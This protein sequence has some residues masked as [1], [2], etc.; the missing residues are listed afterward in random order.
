MLLDKRTVADIT[1]RELELLG[2]HR[3]AAEFRLKAMGEADKKRWDA[4]IK[5][6]NF[7]IGDMVMLTHEGKFGLEPRY[8]GPYIVTKVFPDFGTYQLET[9]AGEPL[10][11]LVHVDR[12]KAAK[13]ERPT[14]PWYDPTS[15]RRAV[16]EADRLRLVSNTANPPSSS[17]SSSTSVFL[18]NRDLNQPQDDFIDVPVSDNNSATNQQSTTQPATTITNTTIESHNDS[19]HH[20]TVL[21]QQIPDEDLSLHGS[22]VMDVTE[23]NERGLGQILDGYDLLSSTDSDIDII[24]QQSAP[25]TPVRS[26]Q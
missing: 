6:T 10:E 11:S 26:N 5:P 15:S 17:A 25:S 21:Q 8:K 1:S 20:H 3:A 13:G 18:S 22:S 12:L 24:D 2:Q 7:E 9:I 23:E 4:R 19:Q 16:R 14:E